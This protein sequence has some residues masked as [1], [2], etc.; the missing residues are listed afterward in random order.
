M[1]IQIAQ[2]FTQIISFLIMLW[3]LKRYAWKPLLKILDERKG[4][5]ESD[6]EAIA[7]QKLENQK[8]M[9]EYQQKL[10]GI[11][12]Q[13]RGILKETSEK[14][15]AAFKVVEREAHTEARAIIERAQIELKQ[16]IAKAK[17]QLKDDIVNMTLLATEKVIQENLTSDK[18]KKLIGA[19]IDQ[20]E[21]K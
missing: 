13:A 16:E 9:K 6:V 12:V 8:L 4:K 14:A 18:Q 19:F 1:R 2:I 7:A 20:A 17:V 10:D 3:V 15:Q 5:I 11:E 21:K